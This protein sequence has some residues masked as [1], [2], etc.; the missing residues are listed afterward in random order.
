MAIAVVGFIVS[1]VYVFDLLF[2]AFGTG[3][4][5]ECLELR[6]AHVGDMM[7]VVNPGLQT[8]VYD[9]IRVSLGE[10][11]CV[12]NSTAC[13][14]DHNV[15]RHSGTFPPPLCQDACQDDVSSVP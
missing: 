15:I 10:A 13:R 3:V 9:A 8:G 4:V 7:I 1:M 5:I 6:L 2:R 12:V 11:S 14:G